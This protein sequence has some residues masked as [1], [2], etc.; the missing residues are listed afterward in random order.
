MTANGQLPA[1]SLVDVGDGFLLEPETASCWLAMKAAAADGITLSIT[2]A[3][4][5]LGTKTDKPTLEPPTQWSVYNAYKQGVPLPGA[6]SVALAA[7]PGTSNHGLGTAIDVK[8]T[9]WNATTHAPLT[10]VSKWLAAHAADYGFVL[11]VPS[12]SWHIHR[13]NQPRVSV[14]GY[15]AE[16][17]DMTP[18]QDARLQD[19]QNKLSVSGQAYGLP[20]VIQQATDKIVAGGVAFP[21]QDYNAFQA[22]ANQGHQILDALTALTAAVAKLTPPNK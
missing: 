22:L 2:Q 11:D 12:E 5:A 18:E 20:Q 6:S 15:T 14:A 13:A 8:G 1:S 9:G 16:E 19:I 17:N 7:T 3:Y 4:R 10:A 21:G